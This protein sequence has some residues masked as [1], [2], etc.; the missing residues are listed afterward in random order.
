M[1]TLNC[2]NHEVVN[3]FDHPSS[4]SSVGVLV[5]F[6]RL[7]SMQNRKWSDMLAFRGLKLDP[8]L[9]Q[10]QRACIVRHETTIAQP[11]QFQVVSKLHN[12]NSFR[13]LSPS[14]KAFMLA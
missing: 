7:P 11:N 5:G 10:S 12:I 4:V 13:P 9:R 14:I 8:Q 3:T 6:A 1:K 2:G